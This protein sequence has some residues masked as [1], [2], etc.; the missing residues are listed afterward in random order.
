MAS[1]PYIFVWLPKTGGTSV[2]H[3]LAVAD[4]MRIA[5]HPRRPWRPG[6]DGNGVT[7]LHKGL[8]ALVDHGLLDAGACKAAFKFAFVRNPWDRFVSLW[9]YWHRLRRCVDSVKGRS[10]AEACRFIAERGVPPPGIGNISGFN[11]AAP[12]TEWLFP[13]GRLAVDFVGR[14]EDLDEDFGRV[15]RV[16]GVRAVLPRLNTSRRKADYRRYY[17]DEAAE[18]VG[19]LYAGDVRSFGYEF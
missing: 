17:D 14:F 13:D 15:C 1:C 6:N 4:G 11:L 16:L 5:R 3:A 12:Q 8:P 10:L 19:R 9:S 18:L 2:S 7:F